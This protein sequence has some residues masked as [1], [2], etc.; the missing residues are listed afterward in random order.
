MYLNIWSQDFNPEN[1]IPTIISVW[2]R[3]PHLNLHCWSDDAL[4]CIDDT[5][6]KY[7]DKAEPTENMF[8]YS[9]ICVEVDLEK[10]ILEE[11]MISLDNWKHLQQ[12]DYK[13]LPCKCKSF[14]EYGNF[15]KYCKKTRNPP[16]S[17]E[18]V[19]E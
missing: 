1:C 12:L 9:R 11:V 17:N 3:L 7:I 2:M 10:G 19:E 13:H 6:G 18:G 16:N 14:H 5:L 15:K 4:R 8:S